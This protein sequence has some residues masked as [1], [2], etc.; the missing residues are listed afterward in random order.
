MCR[1]GKKIARQSQYK[2]T[3]RTHRSAPTTLYTA[4]LT[5]GLIAYAKA[6]EKVPSTNGFVL[7]RCSIFLS[8]K[9]LEDL[10]G[11]VQ[12]EL[13]RQEKKEDVF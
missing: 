6:L 4:R 3:G 2:F 13:Y 10:K 7:I 1:P 8:L 5:P 11:K 9:R 12:E